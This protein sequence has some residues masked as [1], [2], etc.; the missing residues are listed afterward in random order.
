MDEGLSTTAGSVSAHAFAEIDDRS[1]V[2]AMSWWDGFTIALDVY[3]LKVQDG[4]PLHWREATPAMP[5][6]DSRRPAAE[7]TPA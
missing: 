6:R 2:K 7:L 3:R 4:V 1:L 5:D